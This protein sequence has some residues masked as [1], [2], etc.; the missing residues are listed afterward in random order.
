[1]RRQLL[2]VCGIA[3]LSATSLSA[4]KPIL[5]TQFGSWVQF[6][7]ANVGL[8]SVLA[9]ETGQQASEKCTYSSG[10]NWIGVTLG[11]YHDP[12]GAYEVYTSLLK[13]GEMPTNLGQVAAFDKNGVVIQYGTLVIASTANI[14]KDDLGALVKALD[15]KSEKG[16]LPPVRTYL[17]MAG[18]VLGS[19]RYALGP[20]AMRAALVG[21]GQANMAGLADV[22]GF[23]TGAEAI[24]ARYS[25]QDKQG[26]VLLLLDYPTPQL[27]EQ[28]I[29]HLDEVLPADA[30]KLGLSIVR[31][32]SLLSM[33]LSASSPE[34]EKSLRE[35]IGY[36]TQVTWNEPSQTLTD[37]PITSIMVKIFIGTGV[38]M[39]AAFVLGI[40][41]GGVRVVTKIFFPGK[42]FDRPSQME[43]LQ[44]GL[45]G[46]RIDPSD[47]Y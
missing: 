32:G 37:P 23:S 19:E 13:P 14:S 22:A 18:R 33:V 39:V 26:G 3:L 2:L 21:L 17:P 24:L 30:K 7:C 43:I 35:K 20:E 6:K 5:P 25:G 11:Q 36:E 34:Y 8:A 4:Q 46:K 29:H 15:A 27:A 10:D 40:A 38:F 47:F 31:K 9:T 44:L 16:P 41:F 45:S 12:S 1:M 28:H 42:V